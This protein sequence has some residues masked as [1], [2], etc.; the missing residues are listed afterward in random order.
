[1][2]IP[3]NLIELNDSGLI[4]RGYNL[5]L[6][7]VPNLLHVLSPEDLE[8]W[9]GHLPEMKEALA[10]TLVRSKST[11]APATPAQKPIQLVHLKPVTSNGRS[12]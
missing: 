2:S 8:Y 12:P 1:M 9:E 3:S 4:V 5:G 6:K 10:K 7:V 11:E